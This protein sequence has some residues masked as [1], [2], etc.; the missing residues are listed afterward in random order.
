[1]PRE[2]LEHPALTFQQLSWPQASDLAPEG[3]PLYR[4]CAQLFLEELLRLDDG[5][6]C[7]RSMIGQ[8]PEH[9][10]WQT[11]FLRAFHSHFDQLL[12]VEKWWSLGYIAYV[13]GCKVE[14]WSAAECRKKLQSS[15]DV[16][17]EVH[18]NA[19]Q[20]PV[21]AKIT[22]QEAI[23]QWAPQDAHDAIRR[24]IAGLKFLAPRAAP[25][26]R[27]LVE[28]YLKTLVDYLNACQTAGLERQLGMR[29][30][31]LLGGVKANVIKQLN[32]LDRQRQAIWPGAV[33]T[34]IPPW[35]AV[36]QPEAESANGS[37]R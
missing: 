25:E 8:L 26:L 29:G 14:T 20:M 1:V 10:N 33:S 11:A 5:R 32:A 24:A 34:N 9:W 19:G 12:D 2:L 36:G 17:V 21:E 15:L 7:L 23:R 13:R 30:P 37:Q 27:P 3:L 31:S 18:F 4:S 22:L 6:A 16:P 28:L 35:N